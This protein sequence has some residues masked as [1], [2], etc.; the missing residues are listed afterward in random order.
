[1]F[2]YD[3]IVRSTE[4]SLRNL[5]VETIDLQQLHVWDPGWIDRDEW[6]RAFEDLKRDGKIRFSGVSIN[7]HQPD[8]A[9][10]VVASGLIDSVQVIYN[11]FDQSP[12][13]ESVSSGSKT[14]RWRARARPVRRRQLDGNNNA[15]F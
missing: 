2:P 7:D 6:K 14:Q 13:E 9:L 1:M 5:Q 11:I 10:G 3:Y 4:E 8:S 15:K 12:E